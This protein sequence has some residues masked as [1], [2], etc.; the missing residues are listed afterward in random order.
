MVFCFAGN[1]TFLV[2]LPD[3]PSHEEDN[4]HRQRQVDA[5]FAQPSRVSATAVTSHSLTAMETFS[6]SCT[7]IASRPSL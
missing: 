7:P 3:V 6:R 4:R 2:N 1:Y 5:G